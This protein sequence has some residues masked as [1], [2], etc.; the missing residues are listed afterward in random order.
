M[1]I[2][3]REYVLFLYNNL[4]FIDSPFKLHSESPLKRTSVVERPSFTFK[5]SLSGLFCYLIQIPS[6]H[7]TPQVFWL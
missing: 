4:M 1:Q 2:E 7:L 3:R 6:M 5:S